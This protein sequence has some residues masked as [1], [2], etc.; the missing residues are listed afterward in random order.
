M[1][2]LSTTAGGQ[3]RVRPV[4]AHAPRPKDHARRHLDAAGRFFGRRL[5]RR[6]VLFVLVMLA[7]VGLSARV[8]A[9]TPGANGLI[10]FSSATAAGVQLFTVHPDGRDLRQITHVAGDAV[11]VDWSPNGR[12]I[13]FALADDTSVRIAL[14]RPDGSRLRILPQPAGV[15]DDQPSFSPD[16]RLT[17]FERFTVATNDDAIWS[18]RIDGSRQ[19]R[20]LGPF[21]AGF[22]TDPNL[23]PD[24]KTLS[25]QGFDGSVVGPAPDFE[26]AR[27]L[28]TADPDGGHVTQIRPFE[29]DQTIKAD[30]APN[31]RGQRERQ[32]FR[33]ER[34]R[35]HRHHATRRHGPETPHRLPRH[36]D[37]R[38]ARFLLARRSMARVPARSQRTVRSVPDASRWERTAGDLA[39]VTV[40]AVPHRLGFV[41]R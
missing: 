7:P 13:V 11:N 32:P 37:E 22:V 17:Y 41:G 18:M 40:P 33:S 25:F 28:F 4:S 8:D 14:A 6:G 5:R 23:S 10:A 39:S 16:G 24:D 12:P 2:T 21:P 3:Q 36:R 30:W 29:S 19:H 15:F 27:A 38:I 26:P 35:Q 20:V 31:G 1:S 9:T 34:F